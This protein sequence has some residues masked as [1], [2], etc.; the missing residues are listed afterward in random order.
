MN[1]HLPIG[2]P[3]VTVIIPTYNSASFLPLAL[4]S[5]FEQDFTAYEV[6]VVDDGS[7][8][9]T[10]RALEPFMGRIRYLSQKNAGSAAAR[11]R[12]LDLAQGEFVL[13]LD[14]D[15]LLLPGKMTAQV[16]YLRER[17][18]LGYVHSGWQHLD[19]TGQWGLTVEPW[20][21]VP[22]LTLEAW[23]QYKPVQL[24]AILFRRHWLQAVGGLDAS[25]R[26]AHDVDLMLR[27]S[28]AGCQGEWLQAATIGYRQYSRSTMQRNPRTQAES[29]LAMLAKFFSLPDV[30]PAVQAQKAKTYFYSTLWLAWHLYRNG[31]AET[32]VAYLQQTLELAPDI[33]DLPPVYTVVEWLFHFA[34]WHEEDGRSPTNLHTIWPYLQQAAPQVDAWPQLARLRDWWWTDRPDGQRQ[35]FTPFDLWRI[36]LSALDWEAGNPDLEAETMMEWWLLVWHYYR[37]QAY[38]AAAEALAAF[39]DLTQS[40]LL[41]LL[42]FSLMAETNPPDTAL[43]NLLWRHVLAAGLIS[44]PDY[45]VTAFMDQLPPVRQPSVSVI[46]PTY[47]NRTFLPATIESVLEQSYTDYE[48]IVVDD[49]STDDTGA[50]LRPYDGRICL[51]QQTNQGVS[52]ARNHGLKLA[53]GE[54]VVFLDGDDLLLLHKLAKQVDFLETHAAVGVVHS[55]WQT[56]DEN[57][58]P[59]ERIEPWHYVPQLDLE[60]WLLWKPVFLGAMMFRRR[61][62]A[63]ITP[64]FD[65]TLPQAEDTDLLLRL[66]AKGCSMAWLPQVTIHYRQHGTNTMRN[67]RQQAACITRVLDKFFGRTDLPHAVHRLE[68]QVRYY[69]L[70]WVVWN[71][72]R[73]GYHDEIATYLRQT[74][75]YMDDPGELPWYTARQWLAQLS[76]HALADAVSPLELTTFLPHFRQALGV[77]VAAWQAQEQLLHEVLARWPSLDAA[78]RA[79]EWTYARL[80]LQMEA[81]DRTIPAGRIFAWWVW[82]WAYYLAQE[83]ERARAGLAHFADLSLTEVLNLAQNSIVC[84]PNEIDP[85]QIGR[86]W[87]DAQA[88]GL[89]EPGS[90]RHVA[91]LY[92]TYFGQAVLGH[93]W[94]KAF[95]GFK[96][97]GR[98]GINGQTLRAWFRFLH[99]AGQYWWSKRRQARNR[100][101]LKNP[102]SPADVNET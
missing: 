21:E 27:L 65:P 93:H 43:I 72:F 33:T 23:L 28:L 32:A 46:I 78:T 12:G 71:L 97:A 19:E 67:G 83:P 29:V 64:A 77:E 35:R 96:A 58:N 47:N 82:V 59:L 55:G 9:G 101:F 39:P 63:Q 68:N 45:D 7:T 42:N 99:N 48:I 52:A 60:A 24:G 51:I 1:Q 74:L 11:N 95:T 4:H 76:Q 91:A 57:G 100:V 20:H 62:L 49:G 2:Q 26:Q 80:A 22:E 15:D 50:V 88:S 75:P 79:E 6:I 66:A 30:P 36:F 41:R 102:V 61:W 56:I 17:P 69:T 3:V 25:L 13:F 31:E 94:R 40:R 53:Q 8:D 92:L 34:L 5:L 16:A 70:I 54:F 38:G 14:A 10:N 81:R 85:A 18:S 86:F 37:C 44:E 98:Q 84:Q 73:T 89:V 87:A 90:E